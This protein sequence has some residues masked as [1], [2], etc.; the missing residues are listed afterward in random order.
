MH[1]TLPEGLRLAQELVQALYPE[2]YNVD[3]LLIPPFT[4]L[5]AVSEAIKGGG[6]L[7]GAQN[8]AAEGSGAYTGEVSAAMLAS[9]GAG[10]VLVGHSE[11]RQLFG[12]GHAVLTKKVHEVLKAGLHVIYC[13][14]ETLAEREA[15]EENY[16]TVLHAQLQT[17]FAALPQWDE[18]VVLAYEPVW[19]IGTG[20]TATPEQAQAVHVFAR[21]CVRMA[22]PGMAAEQVRILY[23]GS[24]NADNAGTLL[25]RP[26]I[27]GALVGGASLKTESFAA[28]VNAASH[29]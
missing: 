9:V 5:Y 19:A 25:S 15:G 28:I 7:L 23:G 10:Y 21:Q 1:T 26:D 13:F 29:V 6:L 8:C 18:R 11:R 4:H 16:E 27:D 22:Y 20:R 14:G 12:E 17:L 2:A 24:V 3:V